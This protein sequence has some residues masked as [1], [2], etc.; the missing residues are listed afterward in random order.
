MTGKFMYSNAKLSSFL[1]YHFSSD[2][3]TWR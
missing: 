1:Q 2:G 3:W